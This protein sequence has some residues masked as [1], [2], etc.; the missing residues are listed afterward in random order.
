[1]GDPKDEMADGGRLRVHA[2]RATSRAAA[3]RGSALGR[4]RAIARSS[5]IALGLALAVPAHADDAA[6][7]VIRVAGAATLTAPA[8]VATLSVAVV[9]ESAESAPAV[10]ENARRSTAVIAALRKA[11]GD[12][13]EISTLGFSV[14]P[15]YDYGKASSGSPILRGYVVRNTVQVRLGA[16]ARVGEAIDAATRAGA[17]EV[18]SIVFG[19]RDDAPL[20]LRALA[21]AAKDARAK[22]DAAAEALGVEVREIVSLDEGGGGVEVPRMRMQAE[23]AASKASTPI[24]AG[25]VDVRAEVVLTVAIGD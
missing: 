3:M 9:T 15:Q 6:R 18:Q 11:L 1:M 21:A 4:V 19:L 7:P 24:E 13:G 22:A 25:G 20:R 16:I 8:D 5:A 14:A 2:R 17:N 23:F 12:A 10:E